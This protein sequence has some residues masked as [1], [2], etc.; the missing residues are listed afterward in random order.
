MTV[1]GCRMQ[2]QETM[3]PRA[4]HLE[5]RKR[6]TVGIAEPTREHAC[7]AI[8]GRIGQLAT[9][10][11][12]TLAALEMRNCKDVVKTAKPSEGFARVIVPGRILGRVPAAVNVVPMIRAPNRADYAGPNSKHAPPNAFGAT[13]PIAPMRVNA[14]PANPI[15]L[16]P[17]RGVTTPLAASAFVQRVR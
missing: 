7:P 3:K 15:P 12:P 9:M 1:D 14:T 2:H 11:Q 5:K 17:Q 16:A 4:L 8:A 13:Y 10:S 6:A